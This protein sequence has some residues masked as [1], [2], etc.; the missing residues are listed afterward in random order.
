MGREKFSFRNAN[1][2]T[3]SGIIET[4]EGEP[5]LY[6]VFGP[7]FTCVK[8][9]NG[10]VRISRALAER[11]IA[12]L[13][14]DTS[15]VGESEGVLAKATFSSRIT[16]IISACKAL[17]AAYAAPRL[18]VGHSISGTAILS[19]ARHISSLEVIATVCSPSDPQSTIEKFRRQGILTEAE[20][21][22]IIN[23]V[24]RP[25]FF[26][27]GFV[28][29]MMAQRTIEDTPR[30]AQ[31]LFI[32]HAPNDKIVSYDN[33]ETLLARAGKNAELVRLADTATHLFEKGAD[34]AAFIA[35]KLSRYFI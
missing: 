9:S 10:A 27:T 23:V 4:P 2:E 16:D 33:A 14:F 28:E 19:A 21:G 30:I 15:G 24:G 29:D 6:A 8:E 31:K 17:G 32:F 34:D 12:T 20:G 3:L 13:R 18:F 11:G 22:V 5:R 25:T 1:G 26:E 35:E 7:C